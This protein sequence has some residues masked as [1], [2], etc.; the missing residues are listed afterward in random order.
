MITSVM[1][2]LKLSN[3]GHMATSTIQTESH[4]KILL[5]TPWT[6]IMTS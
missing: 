1:E 2:L 4:N 6:E 3:F 5:G